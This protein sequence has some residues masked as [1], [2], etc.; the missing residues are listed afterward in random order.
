METAAV[1]CS[2]I[3]LQVT[4]VTA[5]RS[6]IRTAVNDL[7]RMAPQTAS[8]KQSSDLVGAK[9]QVQVQV[10][11]S[12][13]HLFSCCEWE[14]GS[15]KHPIAMAEPLETCISSCTKVCHCKG[16]Y[17]SLVRLFCFLISVGQVACVTA[18]RLRIVKLGS[19]LQR[20]SNDSNIVQTLASRTAA[21]RQD[22][23]SA[24]DRHKSKQLQESDNSNVLSLGALHNRS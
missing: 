10:G 6:P 23:R 17:T 15:S 16:S 24:D 1:P 12:N 3:V 13:V 7:V 22:V 19:W 5:A 11:R 9:E 2:I 4:A 18:L 21:L 8:F 20:F 14:C